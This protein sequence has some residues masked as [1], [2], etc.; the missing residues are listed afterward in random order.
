[1]PTGRGA[2]KGKKQKDIAAP[3]V[4]SEAHMVELIASKLLRL[5]N[6]EADLE[7]ECE[8]RDLKG[9]DPAPELPNGAVMT[10]DDGERVTV[11]ERRTFLR[12][13]QRRAVNGRFKQYMPKVKAHIKRLHAQ[14]EQ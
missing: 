11:D 7:F 4:F 9:S 2:S 13:A 3:R 8:I 6:M 12:D 14:Q 1:M 5:Q 10:N